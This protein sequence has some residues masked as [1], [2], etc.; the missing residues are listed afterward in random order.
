MTGS[1][2]SFPT[3]M[4]P[5]RRR[6]SGWLIVAV[7]L[8]IVSGATF[9]WWQEGAAGI[10]APVSTGVPLSDSS[11]RAPA[12]ARVQVRVVNATATRGLARRAT[13]LLR[14]FGYDVV[15]FDTD[16]RR[17]RE[18]TLVQVHTGKSEIGERLLRVMG[19][20]ETQTTP[21]SLRYLDFTI[22]IG[23]DWKPPAQPLR[24]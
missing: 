12:G 24:P 3:P 14:D 7:I 10:A 5:A 4:P 21:D 22:L 17:R 19:T 23:N 13:L 20:G 18:K 15:D 6:R 9:A 2:P 8:V 1:F 16:A 11:V